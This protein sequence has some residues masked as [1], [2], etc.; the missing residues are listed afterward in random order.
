MPI[1]TTPGSQFSSPSFLPYW[2]YLYL[3]GEHIA[4]PVSKLDDPISTPPGH[5]PPSFVFFSHL[6]A[7][8]FDFWKHI[9]H[10]LCSAHTQVFGSLLPRKPKAPSVRHTHRRLVILTRS[11]FSPLSS[12]SHI[13]AHIYQSQVHLKNF[14]PSDPRMN[15]YL[16]YNCWSTWG[17]CRGCSG[18]PCLY[19]CRPSGFLRSSS[20]LSRASRGFDCLLPRILEVLGRQY[21]QNRSE[22]SSVDVRRCAKFRPGPPF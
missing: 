5:S 4:G 10:L 3:N 11:L 9:N 6:H 22:R 13:H 18:L 21:V 16:C 19:G 15:L 17:R 7:R 14:V 20:G 12:L 2:T 1:W 8:T